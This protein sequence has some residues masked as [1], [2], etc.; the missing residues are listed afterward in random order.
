MPINILLTLTATLIYV[1]LAGTDPMSHSAFASSSGAG[2]ASSGSLAA[3]AATSSN[4]GAGAAAAVL[5]SRSFGSGTLGAVGIKSEPRGGHAVDM[6]PPQRAQ[7]PRSRANSRGSSA[8][9]A[10]QH[11][12]ASDRATPSARME[13]KRSTSHLNEDDDEDDDGAKSQ[14]RN[15]THAVNHH[16]PQHRNHSH[17]VNHHHSSHA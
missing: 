14:H 13:R 7:T 5:A 6:A 10:T 3:S 15:H 9:S 12:A 4:G 16:P 8:G 17:A 1:L 2:A 11:S